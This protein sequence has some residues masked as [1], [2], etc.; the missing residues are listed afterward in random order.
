MHTLGRTLHEEVTFDRSRVT[1]IDWTSYPVLRFPEA[2]SIEMALI[3]HPD[4]PPF[5]A[6]EAASAPV[7][8][9]LSNA[10]FDTTGV[11]LRTAP[12]RAE[13]VKAAFKAAG[14]A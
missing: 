9:A 4:Q 1:S 7:A 5:R 14:I 10:V 11:P 2:P 13:R 6:A 8:A 3:N 12:F